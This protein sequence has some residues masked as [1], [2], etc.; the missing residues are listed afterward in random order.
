MKLNRWLIPAALAAVLAMAAGCKKD[1]TDTSK[2]LDGTLSLEMPVYVQVGYTKTFAID[3]LMT[4]TCPE[5]YPVGYYFTD[6]ETKKRDTLVTVDGIVR[7]PTFTVTVTDSLASRTLSLTAFVDSKAKYANKTASASFSV[8]KA[9]VDGTGSIT[10]FDTAA[11]SGSFTDPR[12]G[13]QYYYTDNGGLSWM[14]QNLAWSGAGHAFYDYEVLSDIFGRY[15]TW[16]EAKTACPEGWRLPTDAEWTALKAGA[17]PGKDIFGLA[18]KLM[19]DLYFNGTRMWDYWR[20]VKISD[21]LHFS[22]MPT[23]YALVSGDEFEFQALYSYAA[24]W[25]ADEDGDKAA[26]R[27]I[28]QNKDIVYRGWMS[29]S[30]FATTVRCVKEK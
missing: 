14:R 25:T 26:C 8:V 9:G 20:E 4:V 3:T 29:K 11:S 5:K 1:E 12:D 30:E 27:Y 21:E 16:E 23:G 18:G 24:F 2:T 22:V 17:E 7:K 28:F 6:S 15:Y 10:R 19:A 13:Q